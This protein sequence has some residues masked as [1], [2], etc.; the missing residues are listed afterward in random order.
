MIDLGVQTKDGNIIPKKAKKWKQINRFLE[1]VED[2]LPALPKDREITI[3]DFGCGK[4]YLTF[5]MYYYLKILKQYHVRMIGLDLKSDVIRHCNQ[6][7]EKYGYK[8]LKFL[9]GDI[10]SYEG[11]DQVDMVVT[12]H[13][14]DTATDFAL[15]KA[16]RWGAKVILS[17]P[18]C[19][20]EM[21]QQI[22]NELLEPVLKYGILKER[23]SALLTDGLRA[24]ILEQKGYDVQLLEF[25]DMEDTPKNLLIRAVRKEKQGQKKNKDSY[26]RLCQAL[27][28]RGTLEELQK[29]D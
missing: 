19:Q 8:E 28:F 4:S 23:I 15:D 12:L 11:V 9:E 1:F 26:M 13:A 2:V 7:A 3:L 27:N 16:I 20:H 14:C 24:N 21:N 18:C 25:I 17:V 5:A 6:L 29:K 22:H 10:S